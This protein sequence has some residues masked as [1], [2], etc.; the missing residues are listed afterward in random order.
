MVDKAYHTYLRF[1]QVLGLLAK[2]DMSTHEIRGATGIPSSTVY[3]MIG[4]LQVNGIAK[5]KG[6][7]FTKDQTHKEIVWGLTEDGKASLS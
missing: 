3:K 5:V 7:R 4:E 1:K 6:G 2:N